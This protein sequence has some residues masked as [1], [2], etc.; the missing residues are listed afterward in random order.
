VSRRRMIWRESLSDP[1]LGR[2]SDSERLLWNALIILA[3]DDGRGLA[4]PEYLRGEIW[5]YHARRRQWIENVLRDLAQRMPNLQLH[6]VDGRPYYAFKNWTE[7]QKIRK[8]IY[9]ASKLPPPPAQLCNDAVTLPVQGRTAPVP[10]GSLSQVRTE[11]PQVSLREGEDEG[12]PKSNESAGSASALS[13]AKASPAH[14]RSYLKAV[15]DETI[16]ALIDQHGFEGML[17]QLRQTHVP[18]AELQTLD[19][20]R[21]CVGMK[22]KAKM[23]Q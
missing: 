8:D 13:G 10:Q 22:G 17:E 20:A 16:H 12:K 4:D 14:Q 2:C 19:K 21:I 23:R 3:D 18:E 7:F 9:K 6:D 11:K 1:D 5:R 15:S